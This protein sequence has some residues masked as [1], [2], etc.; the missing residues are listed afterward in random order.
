MN[1]TY[2][3]A[4]LVRYTKTH[5]TPGH[6]PNAIPFVAVSLSTVVAARMQSCLESVPDQT[7]FFFYFKKSNTT[8]YSILRLAIKITGQEKKNYRPFS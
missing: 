8:L 3:K 7:Q 6:S 1:C 4:D 2:I 5:T